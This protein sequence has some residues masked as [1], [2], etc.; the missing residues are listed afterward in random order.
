LSN[1]SKTRGVLDDA[2]GVHHAD[3]IGVLG[4]DA[5]VVRDEHDRHVALAPGARGEVED[6]RLD[7]DVERGGR[8]V[9]EEQLRARRRAPSRS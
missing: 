7:G 1:S 5:E 9:G 2:P 4:D 6:L 8:L 3:D